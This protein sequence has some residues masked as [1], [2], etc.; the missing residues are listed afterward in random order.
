MTNNFDDAINDSFTVALVPSASMS[1]FSEK[2]LANFK[3]LL[4]EEINL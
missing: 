3:N 2:T 4:N 1:V